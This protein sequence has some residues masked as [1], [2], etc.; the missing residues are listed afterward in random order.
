M[1]NNVPRE[2]MAQLW[3]RVGSELTP[4][5]QNRSSHVQNMFWTA[6]QNMFSNRERIRSGKQNTL[7][8][9]WSPVY[10]YSENIF[11]F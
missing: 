7:R 11:E 5:A 10:L 8:S 4:S 6:A 9:V 2:E 1:Q 3:V